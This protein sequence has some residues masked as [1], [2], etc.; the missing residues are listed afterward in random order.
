MK[1]NL[2]RVLD[3]LNLSEGGYVN[4]P[5]D[6]GGPT[7]RGITERVWHSWQRNNGLEQSSVRGITKE[8]AEQI[9]IEQ[10]FEP[11]WFNRLPPGLDYCMA[12]YSVNSGPAR[13]VKELQRVL[14][15]LTVDGIMGNNTLAAIND[16]KDT[17]VLIETVC[18]KRLAFM[19]TLRHWPRFKNGWTTR[20]NEV[21][22][23]S[24]RM[25]RALPLGNLGTTET[26]GRASGEPINL[27]LQLILAI[28]N[29]LFG[30]KL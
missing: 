15:G 5:K 1:N 27:L 13:A 17:A 11:V 28:I 30:V 22:E 10:Y 26:Q 7:N 21:E 8:Q 16:N 24:V 9:F 18:K 14:T 12:D 25:S 4:D 29:L 19:K 23:T 6:P 3:W 2:S 20:V